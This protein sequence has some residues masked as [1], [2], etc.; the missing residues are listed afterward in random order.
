MK[1]APFHNINI[2]AH[3][4]ILGDEIVCCLLSF[5]HIASW[6]MTVSQF[7]LI[8]TDY[9]RKVVYIKNS[10]KRMFLKNGK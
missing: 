2:N 8:K 10:H 9:K 5:N 3:S 1:Y 4:C 6:S 7:S